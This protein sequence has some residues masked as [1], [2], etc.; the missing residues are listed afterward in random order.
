MPGYVEKALACFGHTIPSEPQHQPHK[1]TIPSYGATIQYAK[2]DD[3]SRLLSKEEKKYIQQVIG[4]FLYYGRA[5]DSTMLTT[6]CS[7]A[8]T[9]AEPTEETMANT[10]IVTYRASDMVLVVH[11][12]ASYLSEPKARSHASGHFFMSSDTKDPANNGAVY[13]S[14]TTLQ[15]PQREHLHNK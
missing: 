1:H 14:T 9:Q 13:C 8:S 10:A 2:A 4:T 15:P 12:D 3:S 6:L 11:S 7:I 5:V